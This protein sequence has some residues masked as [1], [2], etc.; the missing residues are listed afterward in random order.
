MVDVAPSTIMR[1]PRTSQSMVMHTLRLRDSYLGCT[2][3]LLI[4]NDLAN[5]TI[6]TTS[7]QNHPQWDSWESFNG[8]PQLHQLL[9]PKIPRKMQVLKNF[10]RRRRWRLRINRTL[11]Q[12][13][14][15]RLEESWTGMSF[16]LSQPCVCIP[17]ERKLGFVLTAY[18]RSAFFPGPLEYR[19]SISYLWSPECN[20]I[21]VEKPM[22]N[23]RTAMP[24]SQ[25]CKKTWN[26]P[27]TGTIG[28]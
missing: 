22:L 5:P 28:S 2:N 14:K 4:L 13:W 10:G 23:R 27:E 3:P 26:S 21:H 15:G 19:V 1:E 6:R 7:S 24:E 25:E 12:R 8:F 17:S 9:S 18:N 11:T 20:K 16:H